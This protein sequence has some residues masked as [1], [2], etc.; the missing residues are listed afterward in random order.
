MQ[1][2]AQA[3]PSSVPIED[4]VVMGIVIDNDLNGRP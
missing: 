1:L 3:A 4:G 2:D